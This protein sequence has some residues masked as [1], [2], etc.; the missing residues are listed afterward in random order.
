[1]HRSRNSLVLP[2]MTVRAVVSVCEVRFN[3]KCRAR[4][5]PDART[6]FVMLEV[7]D[8]VAASTRRVGGFVNHME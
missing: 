3:M 1:M 5:L 4:S 7:A 6:R 2:R 8:T